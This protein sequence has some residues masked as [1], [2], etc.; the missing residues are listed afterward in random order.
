MR[1]TAPVLRAEVPQFNASD[2]TCR[3]PHRRQAGAQP[4]RPTG[5]VMSA[6]GWEVRRCAQTSRLCVVSPVWLLAHSDDCL[7]P[8]R[9]LA[10]APFAAAATQ[11][12]RSSL[13]D[14]PTASVEFAPSAGEAARQLVTGLNR[15]Q[16]LCGARSPPPRCDGRHSSVPSLS[17]SSSRTYHALE[18]NETVIKNDKNTAEKEPA[19]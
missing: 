2:N 1:G 14:L 18:T 17:L 5:S 19:G 16:S 9:S 8:R 12:R 7:P 10:C 15:T 13:R 3:R 4:S 6:R 11:S